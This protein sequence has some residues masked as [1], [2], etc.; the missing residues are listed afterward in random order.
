MTDILIR[1]CRVR[2]I[3]RDGWSWGPDPRSL[4]DGVLR[5]LPNLLAAQLAAVGRGGQDDVEI[6]APVVAH[7]RL[8]AAELQS[9]ASGGLDRADAGGAVIQARL[10]EALAG[11]LAPHLAS[12]SREPEPPPP[13]PVL[14]DEA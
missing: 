2:V 9:A 12:A 4:A 1:H 8:S 14:P 5:A 10:A 11:A 6:A 3:R 7:V 13:S